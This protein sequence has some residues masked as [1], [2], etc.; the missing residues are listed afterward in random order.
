VSLSLQRV[1]LHLSFNDVS[2]G[3]GCLYQGK[4]EVPDRCCW[5]G[6]ADG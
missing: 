6:Y 4:D 5:K 3:G 1:F 2:D